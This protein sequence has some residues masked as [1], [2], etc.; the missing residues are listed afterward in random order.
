MSVILITGFEP[1][2]GREVNQSELAL[3]SLTETEPDIQR[4]ILP[5]DLY[6]APVMLETTLNRIK[7]DGV[8]CL[9]E[10]S[11]RSAISI[12]RLA[13]NLLDFRIPDNQGLKV[14]DQPVIPDSPAAYFST[15]PVREIFDA[16]SS[17]GIPCALSVS[18]GTY[19]CNQVFYTLMHYVT[20]KSLEIPAGFI[21]LPVTVVA[22]GLEVLDTQRILA[23]NI[24]ALKIAITILRKFMTENQLF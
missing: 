10:A 7:P 21:H 22:D 17:V 3:N 12:E 14:V 11:G 9:G 20:S 5:V 2:G 15:L 19:L 13:V 1:F 4:V 16:I 6:K 23:M 8:I 24:Q 18:A